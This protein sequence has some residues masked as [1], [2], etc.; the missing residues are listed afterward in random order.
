MQY[1]TNEEIA[2]FNKN[3]FLIKRGFYD[4]NEIEEIRNWV[5]DY[6][7]RK[8]EE[9]ES[10][11]EMAYFETSKKDG[12][13]ILARIEN[14]SEY[15]KGFKNL[16]NS[17]R[18]M[19]YV[20]ALLGNKAIIFKEKINFKKPGGGGFR[21]HQDQISRWETY[22][23]D[24]LNVLISTDDSSVENGCIE[25]TPGFY[26]KELLGPLDSPIPKK[27]LSQM[28]FKPFPSKK[29]D[30]IFFDGYTPHQSKD[31]KSTSSRSNVYLTYNKISEGDQR[32]MYFTRKRKE[33]PPD[34]ERTND[35]K[36]SPLHDYK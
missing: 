11:K 1:F 23:R 21:P 15:H 17:K 28:E 12:T 27:W 32:K 18:L 35:F 4:K 7:D 36:D 20:E 8:P 9:W 5:Y 26:K 6:A 30:V 19:K 2:S 34:N 13:R 25:L 31:N 10:G 14:F 29:G 16:I 33:L 22:A 24:F 3:G